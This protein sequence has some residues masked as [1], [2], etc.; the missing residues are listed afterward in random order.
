[1]AIFTDAEGAITRGDW[2]FKTDRFTVFAGGQWYCIGY[3][4]VTYE[5]ERFPE[6][7]YLTMMDFWMEDGEDEDGKPATI[8]KATWKNEGD[9]SYHV[10]ELGE[11]A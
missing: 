6:G 4:V 10:E 9:G 3:Q 8:V 11:L 7:V 1:M 5:D 2:H